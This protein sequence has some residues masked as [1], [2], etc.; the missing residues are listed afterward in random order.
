MAAKKKA[1]QSKASRKP[2]EPTAIK[3]VLK[4]KKIPAKKTVRKPAAPKVTDAM[5]KKY[6]FKLDSKA[7]LALT[8]EWNDVNLRV[9]L[10]PQQ[11]YDQWLNYFKT[12]PRY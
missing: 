4:V 10:K 3:E 12:L 9:K 1:A 5:F 6:F 2:S 7:F 8:K 11:N